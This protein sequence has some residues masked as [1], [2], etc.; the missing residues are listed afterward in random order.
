MSIT[1]THNTDKSNT[2][3]IDYALAINKLGF[4][5][6]PMRSD[7]K[8]P[9]VEWTQ[10]ITHPQTEKDI[11]S[12]TWNQNIGAING[13]NDLRS[14][15][16]DE[17]GDGDFLFKVLELLGLEPD[18][19]WIVL[20][21]GKGGGYHIWL[22][23][24]DDLTI[25]KKGVLVGDAIN[26]QPFKQIELRWA[27]SIT[28]FPPSIHHE[29]HTAYQWSFGTPTT[30]IATVSITV[31]EKAFRAIA[32]PQQRKKNATVKSSLNPNTG[33]GS[34]DS[35]KSRFDT[36]AQKALDQEIG[37][38]REAKQG[39][40]NSQLNQSAF[41]LGQII[42]AGLLDQDEA[43]D[44]L[45]RTA[46]TI[47]LGEKEASDTIKS[48]LEAGAKK[49]RMPKQIFREHEPPLKLSTKR[50]V[51]DE[52]LANFSADDQ[53]HAEAENYLYGDY[54]AYNDAYGWLVWNG[55]HY[56]PS[57]QRIN[58][59]IVEVLRHR[60]RAAA[61]ME[62][63][64]LAKVSK[65][66][67]GTVAATRSMLENLSVI[68]V[69][70]FDAEPDLINT[71][72][73]IV[74]LRTKT[75]I[76]HDPAYRF[77]WCSPVAYN[78]H[79][80]GDLWLDFLSQTVEEDDMISYLQEALGYSLTGHTSEECLFYIFGPPRSGKGTVSETILS[81]LPR[82]IVMEVDFNTFT[83]KR[84]GDNQ[85]FDLA[86]MKAARLVFASESN[87]YQSLNPAKVKALTGGNLV[88]CAFKHRD[89]FSYRPQYTVWLSSNHEVNADA[90]DDALWGRV[91]VV[92]F[93]NSQLGKE[94]KTLKRRMQAADNLEF[95]LAWMV[96][97]ASQ[98][99][100]REGTGLETPDSVKELTHKQRYDQDSIGLWIEA[101]CEKDEE[102]WTENEKLRTNYEEWCKANGYEPKKANG[103][104]RSLTAHQLET[105]VQ[106]RVYTTPGDPGIKVRGVSGIRLID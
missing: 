76:P 81:I 104:A 55:S 39:Q 83:A 36:W 30:P 48:G 16:I 35:K 42:G 96:E 46:T 93:P 56:V 97:G 59:I 22:R 34:N 65:A 21:P 105:G 13:I 80:G 85:N 14:I 67:A 11:A 8:A 15:D 40:R 29:T 64:D 32:T 1:S 37:I 44:H 17:C 99:Y 58:T 3:F 68:H 38:L 61:H 101:C 71:L 70:E 28:M 102:Y 73:G 92:H 51:D 45:F 78:P 77:T 89:M 74:N 94:D 54:I 103:F 66:Q 100:L 5:I 10:Y 41:A 4:N 57:I 19:E 84:E 18:Y 88:S 7:S 2:T 53:G 12:M 106:R 95:V 31:V 27:N 6:V 33:T 49:P 26:D 43:Q 20:S 91:K 9:K 69:D 52:I 98:W 50:E 63:A 60:Q 72:S 79:A 90:D 47:G 62:R 24:V 82:P 86:P 75:L 23:C 25:S 87:K